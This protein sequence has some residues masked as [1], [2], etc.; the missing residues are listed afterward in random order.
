MTKILQQSMYSVLQQTV[1]LKY[2]LIVLIN[3]MLMYM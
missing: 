3:K 1:I 2:I